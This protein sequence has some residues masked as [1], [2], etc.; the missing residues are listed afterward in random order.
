ML[1]QVN[2][3]KWDPGSGSNLPPLT[4]VAPCLLVSTVHE[5]ACVGQMILRCHLHADACKIENPAI[6]AALIED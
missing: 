1:L 2:L 6:K 4:V 5:L 3:E